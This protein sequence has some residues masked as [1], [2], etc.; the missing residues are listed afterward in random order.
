LKPFKVVAVNSARPCLDDEVRLFDPNG[1]SIVRP[2]PEALFMER[3]IPRAGLGY[4]I[5]SGGF[6]ERAYQLFDK[7][8]EGI[9]QLGRL[10]D[11]YPESVRRARGR[12]GRP[13]DHNRAI[14][15]MDAANFIRAICR[16]VGITEPWEVATGYFGGMG[17]DTKTPPW[18]DGIM[19]LSRKF[20]SEEWQFPKALEGPEWIALHD[21]L[22]IDEPVLV[23][24]VQKNRGRLGT[25][26]DLSDRL[27]YL[28]GDVDEY[29]SRRTTKAERGNT[30]SGAYD[31][32]AAIVQRRPNIFA[33]WKTVRLIG[34]DVVVQDASWLADVLLIRALMFRH[35]Y[36]HPTTGYVERLAGA[37]LV[38]DLIER[39]KLHPREL[40]AM[41]DNDLDAI[42]KHFFRDTSSLIGGNGHNP[43]I[44][45]PINVNKA[46]QMEWESMK[47]GTATFS[48]IAELKPVKPATGTLVFSNG[49]VQALRD[50]LPEEAK[51]IETI[52]QEA[53]L[54]YLYRL[55]IPPSELPLPLRRLAVRL[56]NRTCERLASHEL[57]FGKME[58][59]DAK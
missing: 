2:R 27:S 54:I 51:R 29:L 34:D 21:A 14:H 24:M 13:Y 16:I 57:P 3:V 39:K 47:S 59:L 46:K 32:I 4:T 50:A 45:F 22:D 12:W 15:S 1:I 7:R 48:F 55:F 42:V 43:E 41:T 35:L 56:R 6:V 49:K 58:A 9:S 53:R 23:E 40:F 38:R 37:M 44:A 20:L 36:Y 28:A 30:Y 5:R 26:L 31:E 52:A 8:L 11:P 33:V 25:I 17:H 18:G 10:V 19:F